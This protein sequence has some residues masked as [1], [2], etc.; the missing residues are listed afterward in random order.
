MTMFLDINTLHKNFVK[1]K[2]YYFLMIKSLINS[3]RM[4]RVITMA[5]FFS[6]IGTASLFGTAIHTGWIELAENWKLASS[7]EVHSAG[8]SISL[9]T[10]KDDSWYPV[11]RMPATVL[12]ILQENGVYTDLYFGKNLLEKVPQDLYK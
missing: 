2:T 6:R 8:D 9:A 10:Y 12:E 3:G 7:K 4:F 11:H 5:F 1:Q